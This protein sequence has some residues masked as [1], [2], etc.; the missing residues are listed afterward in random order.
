MGVKTEELIEEIRSGLEE[1]EGGLPTDLSAS[2]VSE[3]AK[4]AVQGSQRSRHTCL[5]LRG[6]KPQRDAVRR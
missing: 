5:A 1:L 6:H 2:A 4:G 3:T